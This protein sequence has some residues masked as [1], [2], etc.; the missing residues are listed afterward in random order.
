MGRAAAKARYGVGRRGTLR[1]PPQ[2]PLFTLD[3]S[4]LLSTFSF[5]ST[6]LR[7]WR[8]HGLGNDYLVLHDSGG[9]ELTPKLVRELCHRHTG[10]GSDGILEPV[11]GRQGAEYGL[12]IHNPDGTE[13]EKSGNGL[14]IFSAWLVAERG[15][16]PQFQVWTAGGLVR[17]VVTGDHVRVDMG[18]AH[19]WGPEMLVGFAAHRVDVGNPHAVVLATPAHWREVGAQICAAVP[20]GTNVQFVHMIDGNPHAL[21]WERG[22][23][24][25]LSSGSS[26]CA[27]ATVCVALGLA[28][29]PVHVHMPGGVLRITVG[30]TLEMEGPVEFVAMVEVSQAWIAARGG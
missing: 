2:R 28:T 26:A 27:V 4:S 6:D 11:P 10:V 25:T 16:P 7:L 9:T 3:F 8:A 22:A 23:G 29:S 12:R 24:E 30:E 15:A 17:S 19:L 13:A 20:G 14:R 21:I 18:K 5:W 1:C